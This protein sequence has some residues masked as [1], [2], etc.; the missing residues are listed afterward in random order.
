[1]KTKKVCFTELAYVFGILILAI[2]TA[3]MEKADFGMSM[4]VAPAYLLHLK[5]SQ[6][7]PFFSFGMA[8]YVFQAFL[9]IVLS[10]VLRRFKRSY[11]LSFATAVIYGLVLDGAMLAIG[12]LPGDGIVLRLVWFAVGMVLCSLGVAFLFHTYIA[13]E[14]YELFVKELAETH[15]WSIGTV[16]TV[17]DCT[18]CLIGILLSFA[19]FGFWHFEGVKLGTVFCA[20]INGWMISMIIRGLDSVFTFKDALKLRNFFSK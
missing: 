11:L 10:I 2:G 7:F 13:P 16:K 12:L 9:L 1:M 20:L 18:S 6:I 4:V 17:Y 5:L 8:E 14:A 19:F 15:G 3:M